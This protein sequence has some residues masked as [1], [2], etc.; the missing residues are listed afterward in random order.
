ML[1][2]S[3]PLGRLLALLRCQMS[4]PRG[5]RFWRASVLLLLA[6]TLG[7][8]I[9]AAAHAQTRHPPPSAVRCPSPANPQKLYFECVGQPFDAI[10]ETLTKDWAGWRTELHRLGI[11]P[12]ASYTTQLMGNPS[13]GRSQGFT[14][15]GTLQ[16]A[17]N[18]DLDTLL[19][20]PA[21]CST[22]AA[23][24]P[25]AR[26]F[27]PIILATALWCRAPTVLQITA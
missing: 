11:T 5:H 27:R 24:G 26:P 18:W 1:Y 14:Y 3:S 13:G 17:I 20:I 15:S 23:P 19:R 21:C 16:T 10:E 4:H 25:R 12:T 22:L 9:T 2:S 7:G 6:L 8:G